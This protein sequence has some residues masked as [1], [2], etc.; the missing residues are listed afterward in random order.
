MCVCIRRYGMCVCIHRYGMCVCICRYGMYDVNV[1]TTCSSHD[2][3]MYTVFPPSCSCLYEH[4]ANDGSPQ[5]SVSSQ[6]Y[7]VQVQGT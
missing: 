1:T 5:W 6:H 3:H 4:Q 2:H 7:P